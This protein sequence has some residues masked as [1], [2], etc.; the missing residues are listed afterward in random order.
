MTTTRPHRDPI[1]AAFIL[2]AAN[3]DRTRQDHDPH[4]ADTLTDPLARVVYLAAPDVLDAGGNVRLTTRSMTDDAVSFTDATGA[5]R[6]DVY[7]HHDPA[8]HPDDRYRIT[9]DVTNGP[10]R[11]FARSEA[12]HAAY[13]VMYHVDPPLE[14]RYA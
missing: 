3:E 6:A 7:M 11:T 2:L 10:R 4:P 5:R 14:R 12:H 13:A 8:R 1:T 9:V